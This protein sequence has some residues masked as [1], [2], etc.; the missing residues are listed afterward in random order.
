MLA[1]LEEV[2]GRALDREHIAER[3]RE[4]AE[5][6]EEEPLLARPRCEPG[7][8][9]RHRSP[10]S[11]ERWTRKKLAAGDRT[12]DGRDRPEQARQVARP[13]LPEEPDRDRGVDRRDDE[14]PNPFAVSAQ[15]GARQEISARIGGKRSAGD[16][17]GARHGFQPLCSEAALPRESHTEIEEPEDRRQG[18][19]PP[20]ER[21]RL[22]HEEGDLHEAR[23]AREHEQLAPAL[24]EA[25]QSC[26][27]E[28]DGDEARADEGKLSLVDQDHERHQ[29]GPDEAEACHGLRRPGE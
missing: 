7:E 24:A 11:R 3:Q 29:H 25:N 15:R 1:R 19:E 18:N 2:D 14:Q 26:A 22:R 21:M 10:D 6:G 28:D 20:F 17:R 27:G 23:R 9:D 5:G 12:E 4:V 8:E 13:P 16:N